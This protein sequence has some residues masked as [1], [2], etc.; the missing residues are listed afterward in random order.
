MLRELEWH[1]GIV[2]Y[3]AGSGGKPSDKLKKELSCNQLLSQ[4]N[5]RKEIIKWT[6]Y[7]KEHPECT[8]KLFVDSGAY[9]AYTKGKVVDVDDYIKFI[10]E[11]GDYCTVFAQVDTIPQVIGRE[12]TVEEFAAVAPKSWENFL[13]MTERV[14]PKY[15]HKIMPV[16]HFQEDVKW[17]K[18]MLEY[19]YPGTD[20]HIPYIGLAVSTVDNG[21]VRYEWFDMCFK[22][23][24]ASSN[25]NVMTHGFG[26][27]ALDVVEKF[28]LT[29]VD[30][31]TWIQT[32]AHGSIMYNK[33]AIICS[34]RR[35]KDPKNI[36]NA[37]KALQEDVDRLAHKY[38]TSLEELLKDQKARLAFNIHY[39][40][41]WELNYKYTPVTESK[42]DLW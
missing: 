29:S 8:S 25:P 39:L 3:F 26:C 21:I 40:R 9:S 23:I 10:N 28:P 17:L 41:E 2:L 18:K 34:D 1:P 38:G 13:Y 15:R 30:S 12:P 11:Y 4:L 24:K 16:F 7:L 33:K 27:T 6:E 22:I 32:A 14:D 37:P 5:E 20:Q 19:T 35:V 36:I 31:T 42:V